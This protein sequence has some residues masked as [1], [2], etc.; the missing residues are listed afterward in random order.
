MNPKFRNIA[1][2]ALAFIFIFAGLFY[3]S[4][5][6]N[7]KSKTESNFDYAIRVVMAHEGGLTNDKAD[8]G[9]ETNF[10]ISLR[11]L[12]NEHICE[13]GDCNG[14]DNEV[15]H[16]TQTEAD[17]IYF[18]DWWEKYHYNKIKDKVIAAKIMDS[19]VNMG[20]SR[21]HK[22]VKE[23]IDKVIH[24]SIVID[25]ILDDQT[26]SIINGIDP[27]LLHDAIR[28]QEESFYNGLIKNHPQFIVFKN[29]WLKRADW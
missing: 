5:P 27:A 28:K 13:N 26:I 24:E 16:L 21:C 20:A 6:A 23:S 18:K 14:D 4:S 25:G 10:G 19:S 9:G 8:K 29:G 7:S 15:I 11:F 1:L 12:K 17:Q 3:L 22:L 2:S